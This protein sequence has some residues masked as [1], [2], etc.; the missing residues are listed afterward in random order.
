MCEILDNFTPK[1]TT[2]LL[3]IHTVH[4]QEAL[5]QLTGL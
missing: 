3:T 2:Q 5:V 1:H 4:H